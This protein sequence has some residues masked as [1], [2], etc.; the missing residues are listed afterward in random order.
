ME[1]FFVLG[2]I[3][4]VF[5]IFFIG[6]Y[7]FRLKKRIDLFFQRGDKDLEAL[8][9]SQIKK[10]E[11]QGTEIQKILDE[12]SRLN[13]ISQRSFQKIG[14]VRFNPFKDVGGDQ[15]FSI[16]LLDLNNNGFIITSIYGRE[17]NRV[18]SKPINDGKSEYSLSEEEKEAIEKA[19]S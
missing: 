9:S 17:G 8:L 19:K 7:L 18:Y 6:F 4:L 3:I 1:S 11:K 14:L 10:V 12:I 16:A 5:L 13:K 2:F 15:S